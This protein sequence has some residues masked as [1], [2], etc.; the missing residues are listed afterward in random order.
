MDSRFFSRNPFVI[1]DLYVFAFLDENFQRA[2]GRALRERAKRVTANH[3]IGSASDRNSRADGPVP[4][5]DT[6]RGAE[7][8]KRIA[9]DQDLRAIVRDVFLCLTHFG[10]ISWNSRNW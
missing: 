5:K 8:R 1:D 10:F 2:F 4:V 9:F 7:A 6:R 3:Y